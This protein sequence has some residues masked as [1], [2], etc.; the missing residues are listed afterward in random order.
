MR[1]L[2]KEIVIIENHFMLYC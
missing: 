1:A 2:F